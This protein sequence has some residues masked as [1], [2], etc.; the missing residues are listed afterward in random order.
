MAASPAPS[1]RSSR[2]TRPIPRR[3]R[4]WLPSA[5]A[6]EA[7]QR[8]LDVLVGQE[9]TLRANLDAAQANLKSAQLKLGYTSVVAPFDGEASTRAGAAVGTM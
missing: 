2:R 7:Q 1:R 6:I 8:Q 9:G 3:W 4:A 5:A